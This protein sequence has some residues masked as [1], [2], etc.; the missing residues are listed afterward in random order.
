LLQPFSFRQLHIIQFC[1]EECR[2]QHS[3]ELSVSNMVRAYNHALDMVHARRPVSEQLIRELGRR[4][5][6]GKNKNGYRQ[7]A[8]VVGGRSVRVAWHQVP[9]QMSLLMENRNRLSADEFY[10]Q[11][12]EIHP[13]LDGNG[14][15]GAILWNWLKGTL[16]EP[17]APPDLWP[18]EAKA[19]GEFE[20]LPEIYA[21]GE[22]IDE[23]ISFPRPRFWRAHHALQEYLNVSEGRPWLEWMHKNRLGHWLL[24]AFRGAE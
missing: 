21:T 10:R 7:I 1:A 12:E 19:A 24:Y 6:P 15:V 23:A 2:R 14:R 18:Q 22:W 16:N 5:E 20:P 3:G 17:I 11:F 13:F 4:V 9:R 8:V